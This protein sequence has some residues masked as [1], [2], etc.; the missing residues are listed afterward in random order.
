MRAIE[1]AA[2]NLPRERNP[3]GISIS[4]PAG[5]MYPRM[6]VN[7]L[8]AGIS[9]DWIA[10]RLARQGVGLIPLSTFAHTEEGLETGRKSFRLTLGGADGGDRLLTKTRRVLIDLNRIIA[11]EQARYN[12]KSPILSARRTPA[13][14]DRHEFGRRWEGFAGMVSGAFRD[15]ARRELKGGRSSRRHED[16]SSASEFSRIV[17]NSSA[18]AS[19]TGWNLRKIGFRWPWMETGE[20]SKICWR[21]SFPPTRSPGGGR[22]SGAGFTIG[23]CIRLRCIRSGPRCSGNKSSSRS[24]AERTRTR[25]WL[26]RWRA[27]WCVNSWVSTWRSTR[28]RKATNCCWTSAP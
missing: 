5:S 1:R 25:G 2:S 18:G 13:R 3:F 6:T 27:S 14:L 9:L 15:L 20:N 12:R 23:R 11:E 16:A 17:S 24:S 21:G 26:V 10:S 8:P 19:K 7:D 22:C 28:G 4:R